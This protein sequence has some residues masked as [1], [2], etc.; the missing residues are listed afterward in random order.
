MIEEYRMPW[1][2]RSIVP[3]I[4]CAMVLGVACGTPTSPGVQP[5]IVNTPDSFEYQVSSIVNYSGTSSY[6]WA[7]TGTTA[8][9][10]IS[11]TEPSGGGTLVVRDASD[12]VVFSHS[13]GDNGTFATGTGTP[14]TWKIDVIYDAFSGT[15][16]FRAE[17]AT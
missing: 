4:L 17:K 2:G 10:N 13:L 16:N 15:V 1:T 14:G 8:N 12:A 5:E 7:N 6:S 11:S 3:A 9:I